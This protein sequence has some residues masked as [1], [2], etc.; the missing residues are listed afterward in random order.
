MTVSRRAF[1]GALLGTVAVSG[2]SRAIDEL[3]Q[4]KL[5]ATLI[6]PTGEDRHPI[7]HLLNRATY[8]PR[9]GQVADVERVGKERWIRRQ[10]DYDSIDDKALDWKLRR[11]D[12]LKM[13]PDDLMSFGR[14]QTFI[15]NQLV[16][17]TLVRAIYSKRELFE[18]M[19]GFWSDHFSINHFKDTD[20]V[21]FLK[22]IDDRDVIRRHA[23]GK[24]GDLLKDSAHSPAML[25]YLDNTVNEN[26]HPNENYARE[27]MELHTLGVDGGYTEQDIQEVARCLTGWSVNDRGRFVFRSEWH[28]N[29]K[30]V[31]LGHE[32]PANG[33]QR[34][35]E[36]V[37]DI[38]VNHPSTAHYVSTKLVRRF[39][40]D[41]PPQSIVD[42]CVQ[43]WQASGGDIK[44][45][46]FTLLTHPDFDIAPPKLKRPYE[47][48]VSL[49]RT[50]NA[51]YNGDDGLVNWLVRLGHRP[52]GWVTPDGYPD[53]AT[54][55]ANN[56]FGYWQLEKAAIHNELPGVDLDIWDIAKHVG[57]EREADAMIDF[58]GRL[59]Y[60]R[61]LN[62]TEE[63]AI[64]S[65]YIDNGR[66]SQDLQNDNNR[67]R[68]LDTLMIL[69][70]GPAFQYR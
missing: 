23:L 42:A 57:V 55:W 24:F 3:T 48:L 65:F 9:P 58:F 62:P 29:G 6:P 61:R 66:F 8:G 16:Q 40:A 44:K 31:V 47:L 38:L 68:M 63:A 56:L 30:K 49:L 4:P 53:V 36:L 54:I 39:V 28:D 26:S 35:G 21:I 18:V 10:L 13:R 19:V 14:N 59:F 17:A 70:G 27:I 67:R 51:Q 20:T 64:K 43:T 32:I 34:D 7:A 2:C 1:L 37:L 22:T 5:P 50:T 45:I 33:G 41:D 15:V 60:N 46:V 25:H 11:F 69:I 12:T 52:F